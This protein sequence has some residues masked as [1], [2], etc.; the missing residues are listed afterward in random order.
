MSLRAHLLAVG[1]VAARSP[2]RTTAAI[3]SYFRGLWPTGPTQPLRAMNKRSSRIDKGTSTS[4]KMRSLTADVSHFAAM[5]AI[6]SDFRL[7]RIGVAG[8]T[9]RLSASNVFCGHIASTS[10]A[11][12]C[13]T[14]MAWDW[15]LDGWL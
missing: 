2:A 3:K 8:N 7:L 15:M 10:S 12:R 6:N 11:T 9:Y 5:S 14:A 1:V 13:A 4:P